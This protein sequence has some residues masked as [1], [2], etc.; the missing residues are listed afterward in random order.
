MFEKKVTRS[1]YERE[2]GY[3]RREFPGLRDRYLD[4]EL[5]HL[6]LELR[7]L[8]LL[9]HLGLEEHHVEAHAVIRERE[10]DDE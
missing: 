1:E 2:V 10:K 9:K 3:L 5:R 6:Q 7:H 4:L 8:Q